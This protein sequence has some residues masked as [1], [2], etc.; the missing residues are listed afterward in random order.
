[1]PLLLSHTL[2]SDVLLQSGYLLSGDFYSLSEGEILTFSGVSKSG[3]TL[4]C[5]LLFMPAL[6]IRLA[7]E[8]LTLQQRAGSQR[9]A[10]KR[11]MADI[12]DNASDIEELQRNA[13]L[14]LTASTAA[15]YQLDFAK[16]AELRYLRNDARR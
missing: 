6:A 4:P 11:A 5:P 15:R 2:L 3:A 14:P 10:G 1:M 13:A 12:I 9:K 7:V 8:H 16:T